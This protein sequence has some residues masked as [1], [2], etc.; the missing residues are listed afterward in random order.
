MVWE[1]SKAD[2]TEVLTGRDTHKGPCPN[3]GGC[4]LLPLKNKKKK[5]KKATRIFL[6]AYL[7]LGVN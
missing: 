6:L 7:Y 2:S 5:K 3:F 4:H 1:E